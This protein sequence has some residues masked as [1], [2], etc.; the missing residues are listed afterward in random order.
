MLPSEIAAVRLL[1]LTGCRSDEILTLR[2][3]DTDRTSQALR[4]PDTKTGL[5]M[6]PPT[7]RVLKVLD[8]IERA[9]GGPRGVAKPPAWCAPG[10]SLRALPA[11]QEGD[12]ASGWQR[13]G[14]GNGRDRIRCAANFAEV[15][16]QTALCHR[17]S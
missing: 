3:D 5:R 1:I 7:G 2:C 9:E 12:R 6:V 16:G 17:V 4:L 14:R 10:P 8:G 11:A 15:V 13:D